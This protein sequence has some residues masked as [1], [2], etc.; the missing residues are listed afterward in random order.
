M[1]PYIKPEKREKIILKWAN[2]MK[3]GEFEIKTKDVESV[4]DL[5]F[6][7]TMLCKDY[8][9]K[10]GKSYKTINDIIGV[11]TC[12]KDEFYRKVAAPYEEEKEQENGSIF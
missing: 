11:L 12:A 9:E 8:L 1:S 5:N 7:I 10:N 3:V 2:G 4:G 6:S